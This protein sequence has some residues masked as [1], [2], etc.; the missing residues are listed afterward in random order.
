MYTYIYTVLNKQIMFM[1]YKQMHMYIH[2]HVRT[3]MCEHICMYVYV[4][5]YIYTHAFHA[6]NIICLFKICIKIKWIKAKIVMYHNL[7]DA[8]NEQMN[9]TPHQ[10]ERLI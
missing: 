3:H 5:I 1:A 6:I 9:A 8:I 7:N 10:R 2:T 4:Y